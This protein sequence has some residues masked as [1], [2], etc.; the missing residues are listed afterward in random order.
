MPVTYRLDVAAP[1]IH[2]RC[3][4]DVT[5]DEVIEHFAT[6]SRDPAC[7]ER[8]DVLLDLTDMTSVPESGELR[9]VTT[10][11]ARVRPRIRFGWCAIVA[12][13]EALYGMA[14]MFEVFA[15]QYFSATRVFRSV[16]LALTWLASAPRS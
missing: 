11:I 3:V 5:L 2:T 1:L 12:S 4:G 10:E 8:L 14:R 13:K 16:D 9:A 7:P 15:E 6:L